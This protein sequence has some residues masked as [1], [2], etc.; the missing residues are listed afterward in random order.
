M[1]KA[2]T[3]TAT[4]TLTP[5]YSTAS[6]GMH[7]LVV[8]AFVGI[9]VAVNLIDAYPEG[10]EGQRLAMALHFSFG[11]LVFALVWLR[12]LLR[13]LGTTPPI[14]PAPAAW[15]ARLGRLGHLVLYL[16]MVAMPLLG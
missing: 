6:I 10:S 15:R 13:L 16:L 3:G 14:V 12:L 4:S 9:Y 1:N 7:W 11:L 8:L 5:R 2:I